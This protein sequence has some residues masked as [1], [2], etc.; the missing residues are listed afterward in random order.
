[1]RRLLAFINDA[2]QEDCKETE[3]SP[4]TKEPGKDEDSQEGA[5]EGIKQ[6]SLEDK[7]ESMGA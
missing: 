3:S 4:G 7:V 2:L 5:S 6:M 1:M